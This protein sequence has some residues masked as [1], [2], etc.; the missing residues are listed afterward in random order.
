KFA[1]LPEPILSHITTPETVAKLLTAFELE[2][3]RVVTQCIQF[4]NN[5]LK[6]PDDLC[7]VCYTYCKHWAPIQF[8]PIYQWLSI[9]CAHWMQAHAITPLV[10]AQSTVITYILREGVQLQTIA[11]RIIETGDF[12]NPLVLPAYLRDLVQASKEYTVELQWMLTSLMEWNWLSASHFN[13]MRGSFICDQLPGTLTKTAALCE[14]TLKFRDKAIKL[15]ETLPGKLKK[16][17]KTELKGCTLTKDWRIAGFYYTFGAPDALSLETNQLRGN[18]VEL[19]AALTNPMLEDEVVELPP[20]PLPPPTLTSVPNRDPLPTTQ[21]VAAAMSPAPESPRTPSGTQPLTSTTEPI[22]LSTEPITQSTEELAPTT[23]S[24]I[25]RC[26][27]P[28]RIPSSP[29]ASPD[30]MPAVASGEEDVVTQEPT[31]IPALDEVPAAE[32]TVT[33]SGGKHKCNPNLPKAP[34]RSSRRVH[35]KVAVQDDTVD[36]AQIQEMAVEV[37]TRHVT[38]SKAS[39]GGA[40]VADKVT[41]KA[42]SSHLKRK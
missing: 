31:N 41:A 37:K 7:L 42:T 6:H 25:S 28:L 15:G 4:G 34:T 33:D 27:P 24:P 3:Q 30:W 1:D 13:E 36:Q 16:M 38:R 14:A 5:N 40:G 10:L 20:L 35:G 32:P 39:T 29:T 8:Q 19:Q 12:P 11:D 23:T 2:A 17:W 18:L 21:P 26:C 22:P 9:V